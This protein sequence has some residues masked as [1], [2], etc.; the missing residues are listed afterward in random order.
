M[1]RSLTVIRTG[2]LAL[3]QDAGRLGHAGD[4]VGRSGAADRRSSALANS[5]VGNPVGAA[6]IECTLGGLAVRA[7]SD[8]FIAVTGAPAPA[9]I[10]GTATT[11]A[12]RVQ[13]AQG[14]D[15]AAA[16]PPHRLTQLSGRQGGHRRTRCARLAE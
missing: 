1:S 8:L 10:D 11:H 12:T 6:V 9:D 14:S 7:E 4:G 3:V 16:H 2:P 5:L 13:L 15:P